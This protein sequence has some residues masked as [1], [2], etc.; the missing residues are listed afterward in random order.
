MLLIIF[1]GLIYKLGFVCGE[2]GFGSL[3]PNDLNWNK[4]GVS[5][6]TRFL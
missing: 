4:V 3:K 5:V 2:C 6:F 1:L